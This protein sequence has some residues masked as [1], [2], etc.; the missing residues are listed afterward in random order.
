MKN[1]ENILWMP[2]INKYALRE[3]F[4]I[5]KMFLHTYENNFW[6]QTHISKAYI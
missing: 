6:D 2:K 5:A 3:L 4:S 1:N